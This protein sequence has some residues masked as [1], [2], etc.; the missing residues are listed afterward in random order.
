MTIT[1]DLVRSLFDYD[2]ETGLLTRKVRRGRRRAGAR[3]GGVGSRGYANVKIGGRSY[4]SH[5]IIWLHVYGRLPTL[6]VDHVNG[7]KTDNRLCNLREASAF[8]QMANRGPR[9]TSKS[10]VKGVVASGNKWVAAIKVNH[11]AIALGTFS[12]LEQAAE[13]Y[14]KAAAIYHG[15]FARTEAAQ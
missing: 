15:E 9:V 1:A 4:R 2:P 11:R 12:T 5:R 8:Q 7:V 3:A 6:Q 13:A 10:G 14:R